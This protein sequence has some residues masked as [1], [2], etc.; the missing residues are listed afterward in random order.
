VIQQCKHLHTGNYD[1]ELP[2]KH[3]KTS[4]SNGIPG[5]VPLENCYAQSE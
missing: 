2:A 5:A 3:T 4:Q 1:D